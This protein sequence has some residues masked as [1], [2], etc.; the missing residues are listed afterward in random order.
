MV[1]QSQAVLK[2]S[3]DARHHGVSSILALLPVDRLLTVKSLTGSP[4]LLPWATVVPTRS[5]EPAHP[6]MVPWGALYPLMRERG[7]RLR[8]IL[9]FS[10]FFLCGSAEVT[11]ERELLRPTKYRI[12]VRCQ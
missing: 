10:L 5:C 8:G 1:V 11:A 2:S 6:H 12:D 3:T 4:G 9:R 7:R